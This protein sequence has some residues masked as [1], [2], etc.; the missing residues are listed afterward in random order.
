MN[1][2][3]SSY[4]SEE[5]IPS[6]QKLSLSS[7]ISFIN[8]RLISVKGQNRTFQC[9]PSYR[10][11]NLNNCSCMEMSSQKSLKLGPR[12]QHMTV[13]QRWKHGF[14]LTHASLLN[15]QR[16]SL[17]LENGEGNQI[18]HDAFL[19]LSPMPASVNLHFYSSKISIFTSVKSPWCH[20]WT[21]LLGQ[22]LSRLILVEWM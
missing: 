11:I 8:E 15:T 14:T 19:V 16:N 22:H 3:G 5:T 17:S 18:A 9:P 20:A 2:E 6:R 13:I 12:L 10:D 4:W 21:K 7:I 1:M